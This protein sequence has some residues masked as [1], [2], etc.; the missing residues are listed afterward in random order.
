MSSQAGGSS[1][2]ILCSRLYMSS[3]AGG[4]SRVHVALVQ[5]LPHVRVKGCG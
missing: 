5:D 2:C 4:S 3:Q 1:N